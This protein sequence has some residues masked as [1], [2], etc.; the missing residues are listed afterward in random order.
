MATR[1]LPRLV[2]LPSIPVRL[3]SPANEAEVAIQPPPE[4]LRRRKEQSRKVKELGSES[5]KIADGDWSRQ[6]ELNS[7]PMPFLKSGKDFGP[8]SNK[9]AGAFVYGDGVS[10]RTFLSRIQFRHYVKT[11]LG[12]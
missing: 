10:V 8:L 2:F 5:P 6:G 1:P 4:I 12:L 3:L 9:E 7:T 11:S